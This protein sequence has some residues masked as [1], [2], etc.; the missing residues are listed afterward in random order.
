MSIGEIKS[1]GGDL[2][3]ALVQLLRR[4]GVLYMAG[5]HSIP[6]S[7]QYRCQYTAL[8]LVYMPFN[9]ESLPESVI[10]SCKVTAGI[11]EYPPNIV[12]RVE[13]IP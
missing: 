13:K 9:C 8:G 3:K 10:D 4:I 6:Q 5:I 11:K 1:G 7:D 12:F 2:K